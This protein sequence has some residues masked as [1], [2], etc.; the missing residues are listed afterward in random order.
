MASPVP[1][2]GIIPNTAVAVDVVV[3]VNHYTVSLQLSNFPTLPDS[4]P[5]GRIYLSNPTPSIHTNRGAQVVVVTISRHG[6]SNHPPLPLPSCISFDPFPPSS[7]APSP[8]PASNKKSRGS[9]PWGVNHEKRHPTLTISYPNTSIEAG[10]GTER[11]TDGRT[12]GSQTGKERRSQGL[13]G[14]GNSGIPEGRRGG[15][16]GE[17]WENREPCGGLMTRKLAVGFVCRASERASALSFLDSRLLASCLVCFPPIR[18]H[19]ST[20]CGAVR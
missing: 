3:A 11:R 17:N 7:L 15:G 10:Q 14:V 9:D 20:R 4:V 19:L 1:A 18:L 12:G 13:G 2:Q 5:V 8:P 16:G 6:Q